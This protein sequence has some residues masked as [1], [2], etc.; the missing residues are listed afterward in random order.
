[1]RE[2]AFKGDRHISDRAFIRELPLNRITEAFNQAGGNQMSSG[3]SL[4]N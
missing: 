1:M 4:G 3:C 2:R